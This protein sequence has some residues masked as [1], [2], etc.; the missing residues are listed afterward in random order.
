MRPAFFFL[1]LLA[2][3]GCSGRE[4]VTLPPTS[5][6]IGSVDVSP[7]GRIGDEEIRSQPVALTKQAAERRRLR[8]EHSSLI[9]SIP[10]VPSST[11]TLAP[12]VKQR[13]A[14]ARVIDHP[15]G[16]PIPPALGE[17]W[18]DPDRGLTFFRL[19]GGDWTSRRV[20]E[21]HTHGALFYYT[22]YP[23]EV[24]NFS[25]RSIYPVLARELAFEAVEVFP[26]FR[27]PT[28]ALIRSFSDKLGWAL[29]GNL[30]PAVNV[31]THVTLVERGEEYVYAVGGV[32]MMGTLFSEDRSYQYLVPGR[33][34]G[35][36]VVE[37]IE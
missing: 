31:W 37:R 1:L 21:S 6:A 13:I 33:W 28:P 19:E 14:V 3:A 29:R 5:I 16:V 32:M 15:H 24:L 20:R 10:T 12:E 30:G 7:S 23:D 9:A 35:P 26:S 18:F 2:L 25:D 17:E 36:V 34:V 27:D 8:D 11:P 22:S 4:S